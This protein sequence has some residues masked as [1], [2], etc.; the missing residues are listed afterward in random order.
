[1]ALIAVF[2]GDIVGSEKLPSALGFL[3]LVSSVPIMSG[4]LIAG[5]ISVK[6]A[7]IT[8]GISKRKIVSNLHQLGRNFI[9]KFCK[10]RGPFLES[11]GNSFRTRK[12]IF[13][14]P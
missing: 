2:T 5:K 12:A 13:K 9:E 6:I 8:Q 1:M 11:P 3:Y 4:S 14:S 10:P 7:V